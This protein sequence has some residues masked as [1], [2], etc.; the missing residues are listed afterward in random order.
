MH[1]IGWMR[2]ENLGGAGIGSR[3]FGYLEVYEKVYD[4]GEPARLAF[5]LD[6]SSCQSM[7]DKSWYVH[8]NIF[9]DHVRHS[10]H[11]SSI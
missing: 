4:L 5:R 6:A 11:F 8:M 9:L 1:E 10:C 7:P 2:L 3:D